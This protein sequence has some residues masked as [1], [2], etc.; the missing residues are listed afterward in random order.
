MRLFHGMGNALPANTYG[1]T[2]EERGPKR[3]STHR[4]CSNTQ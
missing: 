1:A 2:D 4:R 3:S